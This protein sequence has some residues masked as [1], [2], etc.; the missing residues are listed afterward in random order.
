MIPPNIISHPPTFCHGVGPR[1]LTQEMCEK[2]VR[3]PRLRFRFEP[4]FRSFASVT[5][6]QRP[7]SA[8]FSDV[9]VDTSSDRF[10][11]F[12]MAAGCGISSPGALEHRTWSPES[13]IAYQLSPNHETPRARSHAETGCCFPDEY[14]CAD[15]AQ[16]PEAHRRKRYRSCTRIR[17]R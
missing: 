7:T 5:L 17:V 11:S 16:I 3:S 2:L 10:R 13:L 1:E 14:A 4:A 15:R 12:R 6:I 8:G 9:R